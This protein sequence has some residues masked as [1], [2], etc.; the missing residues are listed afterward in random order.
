M[1]NWNWESIFQALAVIIS[2][3]AFIYQKA[4]KSLLIEAV[5]EKVEKAK[6]SEVK[7]IYLAKSIFVLGFAAALAF[8]NGLI[9]NIFFYKVLAYTILISMSTIF[10]IGII[11]LAL[12]KLKEDS[13][14]G[15]LW[16]LSSIAGSI[17]VSFIFLA[18]CIIKIVSG[19]IDKTIWYLMWW[20]F[21]LIIGIIEG[22]RE[23]NRIKINVINRF[24]KKNTITASLCLRN[25]EKIKGRI[26]QVEKDKVVISKAKTSTWINQ[27]DILYL[28]LFE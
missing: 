10:L 13:L 22:Y 12:N 11:L 14:I 28:E 19:P 18:L 2:A 20:L 1:A 27:K 17:S 15:K 26:S 16:F 25:K 9:F 8:I 24:L 6:F 4:K 3:I 23:Y 7:M 5:L 21:M